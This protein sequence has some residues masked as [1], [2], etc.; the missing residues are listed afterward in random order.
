MNEPTEKEREIF[1]SISKVE[2]PELHISITELGLIY[3]VKL[4]EEGIANIKM[5]LTSMGCP[6]GPFLKSETELAAMRIDGVNSAS[7]EIVWTPKWDPKLMASED[8]K[9]MLGIYD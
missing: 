9:S 2:D 7:V 3:D 6:A 1:E 8:A 5:T 4:N